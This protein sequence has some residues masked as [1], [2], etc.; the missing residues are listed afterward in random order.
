MRRALANILN[1]KY[2]YIYIYKWKVNSLLVKAIKAQQN[3]QF[4]YYD[5]K[6]FRKFYILTKIRVNLQRHYNGNVKINYIERLTSLNFGLRKN[7]FKKF[8]K[9]Y[10]LQ[11]RF[12][13][14]YMKLNKKQHLAQKN[15]KKF[16]N[17]KIFFAKTR[18]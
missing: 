12:E 15:I 18:S 5:S 2:N 14:E 17:K 16:M 7:A 8:I 4:G 13:L 9:N 11:V 10:Y 6:V 3:I 1:S